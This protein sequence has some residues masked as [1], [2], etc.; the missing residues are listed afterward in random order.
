MKIILQA[1]GGRM[2]SGLMD[3][4]EDTGHTWDMVLTKPP[5][6]VTGYSGEHVVDRPPFDT[7]CNFEWTGKM[8]M[9]SGARLYEMIDIQKS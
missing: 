4:P 9:S 2:R 1:F 3:V 6:V 8:E 7:R 5:T